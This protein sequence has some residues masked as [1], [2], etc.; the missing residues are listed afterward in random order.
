LKPYYNSDF[1]QNLFRQNIVS[2]ATLETAQEFKRQEGVIT[3]EQVNAR[4]ARKT[5]SS[6]GISVPEAARNRPESVEAANRLHKF[7]TEN[8][9]DQ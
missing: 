7:L 1:F 3:Q 2:P 9:N 5:Y 4:D 6:L 8:S